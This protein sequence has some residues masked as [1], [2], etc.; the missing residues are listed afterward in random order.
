MSAVVR[1]NDRSGVLAMPIA[2]KERPVMARSKVEALQVGRML[3]EPEH[4][5]LGIHQTQAGFVVG[6]PVHAVVQAHSIL[7][8]QLL[9][10]PTH[11]ADV[12]GGMVARIVLS[13]VRWVVGGCVHTDQL[14]GIDDEEVEAVLR[15]RPY[16]A[17]LGLRDTG[18]QR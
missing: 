18:Q 8:E 17:R 7:V 4:G 1:V 15:V 6:E 14:F 11:G 5:G 9:D 3:D 16:W 13:G 10:A 2:V 12:C